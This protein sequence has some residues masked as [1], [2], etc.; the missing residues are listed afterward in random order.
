VDK[1]A[2]LLVGIGSIAPE[3]IGVVLNKFKF[4]TDAEAKAK[5]ARGNAA[6]FL[7]G[8]I[9]GLPVSQFRTG[10]ESNSVEFFQLRPSSASLGAGGSS[11]Q[12][13][14]RKT[15]KQVD[16]APVSVVCVAGPTA[17]CMGFKI[18]GGTNPSD[19]NLL[20]ELINSVEPALS[21][22]K[23]ENHIRW[24]VLTAHEILNAHKDELDRLT[25]AFSSGAP[26]EECISI[27]E[28]I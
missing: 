4:A 7:V 11:T 23:A 2:F 17:E 3:L 8:Y 19:V 20:Y 6:K 1:S 25:A 13:F 9:L 18:A 27:I 5:Y 16:I 21:P 14:A 10:G 26:L 15:F 12:A 28:G 24:S 22:D